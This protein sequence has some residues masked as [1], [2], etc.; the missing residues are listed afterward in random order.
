MLSYYLIAYVGAMSNIEIE[1]KSENIL[2]LLSGK[3]KMSLPEVRK[4]TRYK[5]A[6]LLS[7]VDFLKKKGKIIVT[8]EADESYL[9][10]C[11]NSEKL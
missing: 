9:E 11:N 8:D 5:K 6:D 10:L 2:A 7:A 3:G 4:I 1:I